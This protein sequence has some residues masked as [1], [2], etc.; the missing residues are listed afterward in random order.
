ML[1]SLISMSGSQAA[2]STP[3]PSTGYAHTD[4]FQK[5]LTTSIVI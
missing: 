1:K 5:S 4:L 3:L 2:F